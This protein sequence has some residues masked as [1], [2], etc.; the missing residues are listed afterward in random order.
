MGKGVVTPTANTT[1]VELLRMGAKITF[2][3]GRSLR[4]ARG[5]GYIEVSNEFGSLGLWDIGAQDGVDQ[6]VSDLVR[7][8]TEHDMDLHGEPLPHPDDEE[9]DRN[10]D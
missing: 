2:G 3:S 7:D 1:L 9:N 4:G 10:V 8:A 6:A 5:N